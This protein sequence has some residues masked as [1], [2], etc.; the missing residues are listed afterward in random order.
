M[1]K[2]EGLTKKYKNV[3]ALDNLTLEIPEGHIFGFIGPNGAGKTTTIRILSGL[4][5]STSGKATVDGIDV[6]RY[7]RKIRGLVGYMPADFGVYQ[8]MRVWEYLDFFGAAFKIPKKKRKQRIDDVLDLTRTE[9]MRDYYVDSLSTGMKQRVGIAKTLMHDPKVLFLDEPAS[10]LDPRARVEMRQL[11]ATL[12]ELGKTILVS[13]H[14]LPEL[15]SICDGIGI[16]QKA[17]LLI[18][19]SMQSVMKGVR[20]N[21]SIE[22]ELRKRTEEAITFLLKRYP[23][24]KLTVVEWN[25]NLV[26]LEFDGLD[27][28]IAGI[29]KLLVDAGHPVLWFREVMTDLEEIFLKVTEEAAAGE[30][31]AEEA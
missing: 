31:A 19:G 13:S 16:I 3:V 4:L 20:K 10:G 23:R 5:G 21:R 8:E 12:K 7:P 11:L 9:E 18:S 14:I 25:D 28:E 27:A 15:A 1:I 6:I 17:K 26:R 22:I 30:R 2:T 24:E 29:L